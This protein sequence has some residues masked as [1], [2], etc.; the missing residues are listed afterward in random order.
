MYLIIL[1]IW[2]K[3]QYSNDRLFSPVVI[4]AKRALDVGEKALLL[5]STPLPWG[6][7]LFDCMD[8]RCLQ[9]D[10]IKSTFY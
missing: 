1:Y 6:F 9:V 7:E 3:H 5:I 2:Y 4:G 8:T 10:H